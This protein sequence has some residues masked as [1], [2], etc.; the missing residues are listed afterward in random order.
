MRLLVY[1]HLTV[2]RRWH[3]AHLQG[4]QV[5]NSSKSAELLTEGLRCYQQQIQFHKRYIHRKSEHQVQ[6][7]VLRLSVYAIA[8]HGV[9]LWKA[10]PKAQVPVTVIDPAGASA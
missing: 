8:T 4:E 3:V 1:L 7:S 10:F 2:L 5:A 6:P 9:S